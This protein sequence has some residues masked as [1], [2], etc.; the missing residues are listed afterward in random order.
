VPDFHAYLDATSAD[1][2]ADEQPYGYGL[3]YASD[4]TRAQDLIRARRTSN[5]QLYMPFT[6]KV[7]DDVSVYLRFDYHFGYITCL[8]FRVTFDRSAVDVFIN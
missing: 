2:I 4:L 1:I 7:T 5:G 6:D 3:Q 8:Y